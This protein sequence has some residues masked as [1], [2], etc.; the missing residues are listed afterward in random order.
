MF[1]DANIARIGRTRGRVY[2][3]NAVRTTGFI[4]IILLVRSLE[5]SLYFFD[6][7][8]TNTSTATS[9]KASCVLD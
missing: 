6:F 5:S 2:I 4:D 9:M 8:N 7:A 3:S 1:E